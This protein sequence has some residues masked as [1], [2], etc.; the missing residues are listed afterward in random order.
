MITTTLLTTLLVA[1]IVA[2]LVY[3]LFTL[4]PLPE[5]FKSIALCIV[6]LLIIVWVLNTVGLL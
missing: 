5:P 1:V 3:W 6:I 2:G 4:L